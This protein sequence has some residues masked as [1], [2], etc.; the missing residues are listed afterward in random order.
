MFNF[1][2]FLF[3]VFLLMHICTL[4]LIAQKRIYTTQRITSNPPIIDGVLNDP[5]WELVE[6][7]GNFTQHRPYD[8][9]PP[10]QETKFKILYDDKNL[11]IAYRAYDTEPDKIAEITSPHDWFPGDWIEINIDSYFDKRT[12]FSFTLSV[13]GVKGDEFVSN[14]GDNWDTSWNPIWYGKT[15]IDEEGWTAELQIPL[16][17]LRYGNKDEQ[18]WGIEITR[19]IFRKEERSCWQYFPQDTSGWVSNFGELHG[20]KGIKQQRHIELLPYIVGKAQRFEKEQGNPFADGSSEDLNLGLDGK[21]GVTSDMILDFTIN[22]DFGQVEAD[23]SEVNLTEFETY[24]REKRPFFIEGSNIFNFQL[25]YAIAGGGRDNLFYSRRIGHKPGHYPD[26]YDYIDMPDNT[27]ILGAFKLSG[28]TK[29][30]LSIGIMES[31]TDKEKAEIELNNKIQKITVEPLTNY[32][33]SRIIKDFNKGN[34]YLGGMFTATNRKIDD[35]AL[36]YM[37]KA[38]YTGGIDFFHQWK[39]KTFHL[40]T[41]A[42]V[43]KVLGDKE[44]ILETQTS[45]A[46]YYQ[47]PDNNYVSV[48]SSRTSLTGH[49]G[50]ILVGKVSRGRFRFE[51]GIS[52]RSPGF[53][54]NDVGY[55]RKADQI[56]QFTW[57]GY[58][59]NEPFSIFRRF[60]V[61]ANQWC[62]W[63]F[64]GVNTSNSVNMNLNATFLNN[65]NFGGGVTRKFEYI[66]N[67]ILRGGPSA[68]RPGYWDGNFH[69]NSDTRKR[70][71]FGCGSGA[72]L[73]DNDNNYWKYYWVNLNFR[74]NNQL[75]ISINPSYN[76]CEQKLEYVSTEEYE[77]EDRYIFA[78]MHQKTSSITFR[79]DYCITPNF[80]IRYYGSPFIS[81]GKYSN[82]KKISDYPLADKYKD[83]FVFFED[84]EIVYNHDNEEYEID[85][86]ADG[87]VDYYVDNPDFNFKQFNSNL[88]I[89]WEFRPGSTLYLVW[90]QGRTDCISIGDFSFKGDIKDL[91]NVH[92]HNVFLIKVNH[93]F[94]L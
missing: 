81:A 43:S 36:K 52:W 85:E 20:I 84:D 1:K 48:D 89:K 44:A 67:N 42:A 38:A 33:V 27:T 12:A 49:A 61:N 54:L 16:N 51:T 21:I 9:Q 24:F 7:S 65:S 2:K 88:V 72:G 28:K 39:D 86:N 25:T 15:N 50:T 45:S 17:Q 29:K 10:S 34:S 80:S 35:V 46:R 56:N 37:H 74:P 75:R 4:P 64:G 66:S 53:E 68:K 11:Y 76:I 13:S 63:D 92:P 41:T 62:N 32:F 69:F 90:S 23:P 87:E 91:F 58:W 14:D 22:P 31:L 57:V 8:G 19:R 3:L 47:R 94:S 78:K 93:W 77:G 73:G 30:G 60:D 70:L 18:I 71:S 26:N 82:F 59:I 6:W 40:K 5:V 55:L 83:R 79:L